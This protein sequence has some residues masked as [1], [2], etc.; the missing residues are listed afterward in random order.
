MVTMIYAYTNWSSQYGLSNPQWVSVSS[1]KY[2][3]GYYGNYSYSTV[4]CDT[5]IPIVLREVSGAVEIGFFDNGV[6]KYIYGVVSSDK[7]QFSSFTISKVTARD[8]GSGWI[9]VSVDCSGVGTGKITIDGIEKERWNNPA[10]QISYGTQ[11]YVG[12]SSHTYTICAEVV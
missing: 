10:N 5:C 12:T 6:L 9:S 8:I 1:V 11:F 4:S 7:V 3:F 2:A